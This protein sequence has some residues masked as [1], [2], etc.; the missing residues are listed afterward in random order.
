M[1]LQILLQHICFFFGMTFG[2]LCFSSSSFATILVTIILWPQLSGFREIFAE[3]RG[4]FFSNFIFS[5]WVGVG[6]SVLSS[7]VVT[8]WVSSVFQSEF[9]SSFL[10]TGARLCAK[11]L[12]ASYLWL[13][14]IMFQNMLGSLWPDLDTSGIKWPHRK[15]GKTENLRSIVFDSLV[16]ILEASRQYS[17]KRHEMLWQTKIVWK[18]WTRVFLTILVPSEYCR[19]YLVRNHTVVHLGLREIFANRNFD[20][21]LNERLLS[22]KNTFQKTAERR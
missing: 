11:T 2:R 10:N 12:Q 1:N 8:F 17:V 20:K 7:A 3:T 9:W 13:H 21:K 4:K 18:S 19:K 16:L 14:F 15:T 22:E 6:F 5:F